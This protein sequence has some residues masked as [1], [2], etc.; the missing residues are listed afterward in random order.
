MTIPTE[1]T[2][3]VL[4]TRQFLLDLLDPKKTPRV[5]MR[6]RE[7]AYWC[8]RHYPDT[9]HLTRAAIVLPESWGVVE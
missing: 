9:Y 8:L 4:N 7:R 6:I 2:R 5:P 1:R 3:S